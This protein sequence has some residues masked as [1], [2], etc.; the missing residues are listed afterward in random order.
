M[1]A[2]VVNIGGSL[3]VRVPEAVIRDFNLTA[4][5]K[6]E[7]CFMRDDTLLF[8]RKSKARDGWDAAFARY[9]D[10]GEDKLMMPDFLD[11]ETDEML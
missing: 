6:V 2:T 10:E 7:I 11:T 9:A 1:E 3:G 4:G 5:T 8:G